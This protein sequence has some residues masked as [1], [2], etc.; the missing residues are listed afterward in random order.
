MAVRRDGNQSGSRKKSKPRYVGIP[1]PAAAEKIGSQKKLEQVT[2]KT[3]APAPKPDPI[4]RAHSLRVKGKLERTRRRERIIANRRRRRYALKQVNRLLKSSS[5]KPKTPSPVGIPSPAAAKKQDRE[6]RSILKDFIKVSAP[7]KEVKRAER[8]RAADRLAKRGVVEPIDVKLAQGRLKLIRQEAEKKAKEQDDGNVLEDVGGAVAG[9]VKSVVGKH[10]PKGEAER[11]VKSRQTVKNWSEFF[12]PARGA[13]RQASTA[14][15]TPGRVARYLDTPIHV[16]RALATDS[17]SRSATLKSIPALLAGLA[18]GAVMAAKTAVEDPGKL[19]DMV[20]EDFKERYGKGTY[21]DIKK[22][23]RRHGAVV[24]G[25]DIGG[26]AAVGGRAATVGLKVSPK[27]RGF[28]ERPRPRV[29]LAEGEPGITRRQR[30]SPNAL[31]LALQRAS[32]KGQKVAYDRRIMRDVKRSKRTRGVQPNKGEVVRPLPLQS[33]ALK[34]KLLTDKGRDVIKYAALSGQA[35]RDVRRDHARLGRKKNMK[36][37]AASYAEELGLPAA[38]T[39]RAT[40]EGQAALGRLREIVVARREG[41][42]IERM[43]RGEV[44]ELADLDYLIANYEKVFTP[45]LIATADRMRETALAAGLD[46][47]GFKTQTAQLRTRGPQ[48]RVTGQSLDPQDIELPSPVYGLERVGDEG[49]PLFHGTT[50]EAAAAIEREGFRLGEKTDAVYLGNR[51]IAEQYNK[52]GLVETRAAPKNAVRTDS[53]EYI[54]IAGKH[55][56]VAERNAALREAGYDA[57]IQVGKGGK[58]EA[59]IA[60]DPGIIKVGKSKG[61]WH[62]TRDGKRVPQRF[63]TKKEAEAH[64]KKLEA[65][66]AMTRRETDAEVLKRLDEAAVAQG[67]RP[68]G[69]F[70]HGPNESPADFTAGMNLRAKANVHPTQYERFELG[71]VPRDFKSF[72]QAVA[73]NLKRR[74]Q[75]TQNA[76]LMDE[77]ALVRGRT[78]SGDPVRQGT[79]KQWRTHF[80][81]AERDP[82]DFVFVNSVKFTNRK[83]DDF[84]EMGAEFE[85]VIDG[86]DLGQ[87]ASKEFESSTKWVAV[88]RAAYEA[89]SPQT[90]HGIGKGASIAGRLAGKVIKGIPTKLIL[91][92]NPSW[93]VL[94]VINDGTLAALAGVG[95]GTVARSEQFWR[96]AGGQAVLKEVQPYIG[97]TTFE[98]ELTGRGQRLGHLVDSDITNALGSVADALRSSPLHI[99]GRA[100]E[101]AYAHRNP[102]DWLFQFTHWEA[103]KFRRALLYKQMERQAYEDLGSALGDAMRMTDPLQQVFNPARPART[104]RER[105]MDLA[106]NRELMEEFGTHVDRMMGNFTRFGPKERAILERNVMFYGFLRFSVRFTFWTMPTRHPIVSSIAGHMSQLHEKEVRRLMGVKPDEP[107]LPGMLSKYYFIKDGKLME[108]PLQRANPALNALT[109]GAPSLTGLVGALPPLVQELLNQIASKDLYFDSPFRLEGDPALSHKPRLLQRKLGGFESLAMPGSPRFKIALANLLGALAPYRTFVA[110][111]KD[112]SPMS[113][114]SEPLFYD[115]VPMEYVD[116][117]IATDIEYQ[118]RQDVARPDWEVIRNS[119]VV[120]FPQQSRDKERVRRYLQ[121]LEIR[122]TSALQDKLDL[123]RDFGEKP[124]YLDIYIDKKINQKQREVQRNL[125]RV[126]LD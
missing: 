91:G 82:N 66:P 2:V 80:R 72:E 23:V 25:L 71:N 121:D 65:I 73:S 26:A 85:G 19:E 92:L 118:R 105:M 11:A 100:G 70:P 119:M 4:T 59:V 17:K 76:R 124:G 10:T 43:P 34:R 99:P 98:R 12:G 38:T 125:E 35:L 36:Q 33:S 114:E 40:Q 112:R 56:G 116:P 75:W 115:R 96:S 111:G 117:K 113:S 93:A 16:G 90:P 126:G 31:K 42:G 27:T 104:V 20:R 68:G 1:S 61:G 97:A 84:E 18:P 122:D 29:R 50:P 14:G 5:K 32:D 21:E 28:V 7:E 107:L 103:D 120:P 63:K 67:L 13:R 81:S 9:A 47:P 8:T 60:L 87:V 94:Q 79:L 123:I 64:K 95:P 58:T 41:Q 74:F 108:L 49:E 15:A 44:D 86:G 39:A 22:G 109:Q 89:L 77:L 45:K 62:V 30:V 69:Y 106:Q 110:P 3:S 88:P 83:G 54:E 78:K 37:K 51:A 6:D 48:A 55:S 52:G 57:V 24:Y 101:L 53:N 46:D 102:L